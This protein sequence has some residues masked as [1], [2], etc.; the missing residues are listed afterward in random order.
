MRNTKT[1]QREGDR[2]SER[3]SRGAPL[4]AIVLE[5]LATGLIVVYELLPVLKR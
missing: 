3:L 1:H 5:F 2:L 4:G